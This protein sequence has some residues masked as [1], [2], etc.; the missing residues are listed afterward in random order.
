V[1]GT[2]A[3]I[4]FPFIT[5]GTGGFE[6]V[7]DVGKRVFPVAR[8]LFEDKVANFWCATNVIIKW[9]ALFSRD[10]TVLLALMT[11]VISIFPTMLHMF[12]RPTPR[13]FIFG[14]MGCALSFFLFSFQVHEKSILLPL[15]PIAATFP[16]HPMLATTATLISNASMFPLLR[17]DLLVLPY[18]VFQLSLMTLGLFLS[19]RAH[20]DAIAV[21]DDND[22]S[23]AKDAT[24]SLESTMLLD[25][26]CSGSGGK[27][28]KVHWFRVLGFVVSV[29]SVTTAHA[30]DLFFPK[31]AKYPDLNVYWFVILG[32]AY[33]L[34]FWFTLFMCDLVSVFRILFG[35]KTKRKTE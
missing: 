13:R 29:C 25:L 24:S 6:S 14:L 4:L 7:I 3:L 16:S 27:K 1:I 5:Q 15:L 21:Y 11:T 19:S 31:I 12:L 17:R 34:F 9:K 2:F 18:A 10:A 20:Y 23:E 28:D 26:I 33:F 22:E 32:A 30:L 8:G 35:S